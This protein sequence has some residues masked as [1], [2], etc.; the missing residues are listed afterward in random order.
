MFELNAQNSAIPPVKQHYRDEDA[1]CIHSSTIGLHLSGDHQ[2]QMQMDQQAE[3]EVQNILLPGAPVGNSSGD[4]VIVV[5]TTDN[6]EDDNLQLEAGGGPVH[7]MVV[8]I[9]D[10]GINPESDFGLDSPKRGYQCES[11]GEC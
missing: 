7:Q 6:E 2:E 5:N 4:V 10:M 3:Q 1:I 9:N 11:S 8:D